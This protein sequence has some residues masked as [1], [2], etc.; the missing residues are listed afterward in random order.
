MISNRDGGENIPLSRTAITDDKDTKTGKKTVKAQQKN[1]S[2]KPNEQ[3][4]SKE[5]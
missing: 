5:A 4:S 2:I 3:R 1:V